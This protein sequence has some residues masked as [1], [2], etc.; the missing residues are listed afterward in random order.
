MKNALKM[1][2]G[3][4][5]LVRIFRRN[6]RTFY[7]FQAH[8][9]GLDFFS[10]VYVDWTAYPVL[11]N[12]LHPMFQILGSYFAFT[13]NF[14]EDRKKR[15][16]KQ[17]FN[18]MSRLSKLVVWNETLKIA[19]PPYRIC[20]HFRDPRCYKVVS[21]LLNKPNRIKKFL[22]KDDTFIDVG[23][24]HGSYSIIAGKLVGPRGLVVA[25][26][27]NPRLARLVETSLA[28]NDCANFQVH[29]M[30]CGN[31]NAIVDFF[32]PEFNSGEAGIYSNFSATYDHSKIRASLRRFDQHFNWQNFPG[33]IFMKVD[34]EGSE[35]EFLLGAKEMIITRR[36]GILLEVNPWS[37]KCAKTTAEDLIILLKKLGYTHFMDVDNPT[38]QISLENLNATYHQNIVMFPSGM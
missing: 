6:K 24:N 20:L 9:A 31:R 26:E 3:L 23:A 2:P 35:Y 28:L 1:I 18:I 22:N 11:K 14:T 13:K 8:V 33:K 4:T 16:R 36:P 30:A 32:I 5:R 10:D 19:V 29:Q 17:A 37:L 7:P 21:E 12:Q 27:P 34:V 38:K 25:I 15:L